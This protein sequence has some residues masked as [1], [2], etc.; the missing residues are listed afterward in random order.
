MELSQ[1]EVDGVTVSQPRAH[2]HVSLS[3]FVNQDLID[4]ELKAQV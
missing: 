4:S 3:T 1:A 2:Y